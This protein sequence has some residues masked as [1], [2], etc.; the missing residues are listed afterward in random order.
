MRTCADMRAYYP[1][2]TQKQTDKCNLKFKNLKYFSN[3]SVDN[4]ETSGTVFVC[5]QKVVMPEE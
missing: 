5:W 4:C 3:K 2:P 1:P